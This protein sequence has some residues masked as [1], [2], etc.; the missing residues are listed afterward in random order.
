MYPGPASAAGFDTAT[1][2]Q[3]DVCELGIAPPA[4]QT[5]RVCTPPVQAGAE[6]N[7]H[8]ASK[9]ASAASKRRPS[10]EPCDSWR[11]AAAEE[12]P[13]HDSSPG[14]VE[15]LTNQPAASAGCTARGLSSCAGAAGACAE[16]SSRRADDSEGVVSVSAKDS[17]P[18]EQLP[19]LV[20]TP[21]RLSQ[22]ASA[23][24]L[25]SSRLS[26][27][28]EGSLQS[29]RAS[30]E[31]SDSEDDGSLLSAAEGQDGSDGYE[32]A[33]S[34]RGEAIAWGCRNSA[35]MESDADSD[36]FQDLEFGLGTEAQHA[37]MHL[38][39]ADPSCQPPSCHAQSEGSDKRSGGQ[40][41]LSRLARRYRSSRTGRRAARRPQRASSESALT[42]ER[43][44]GTAHVH[45]GMKRSRTVQ[46]SPK[47]RCNSHSCNSHS[48]PQCQ[49]CCE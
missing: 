29:A 21:Q 35:S 3:P 42:A 33:C 17:P 40:M 41:P 27:S 38:A 5:S 28:E 12:T 31:G 49:P 13:D 23:L 6:S 43:L 48:C 8:A 37:A 47:V 44:C 20:G 19:S 2:G 24:C 4:R 1:T 45:A 15:P 11:I 16:L 46:S 22:V 30:Q 9:A 10:L 18:A 25:L 36:D 26:V 34:Y 14:G 7:T 39:A 32:S